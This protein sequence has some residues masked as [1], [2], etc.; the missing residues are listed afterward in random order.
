MAPNIVKKTQRNK[1]AVHFCRQKQLLRYKLYYSIS[2]DSQ[3]LWCLYGGV[4]ALTVTLVTERG[5]NGVRVIQ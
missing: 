4:C 2:R 1:Q 5:R 3:T